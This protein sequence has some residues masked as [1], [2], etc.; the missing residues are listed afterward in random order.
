MTEKKENNIDALKYSN[1]LNNL[2]SGNDGNKYETDAEIE[3]KN[4]LNKVKVF[5]KIT[6]LESAKQKARELFHINR[7]ISYIKAGNATCAIVN[8]A[9]LLRIVVN[10]DKELICYNFRAE[11]NNE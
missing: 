1:Y 5:D 6:N 7:E 4:F 2:S 3:Y 9:N 8:R 10:S 11:V